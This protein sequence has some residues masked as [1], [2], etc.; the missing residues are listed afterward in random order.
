LPGS[1]PEPARAEIVGI[2]SDPEAP[3]P[4]GLVRIDAVNVLAAAGDGHDVDIEA[5]DGAIYLP[6]RVAL[7]LFGAPAERVK[8][9]T[10]SGTSM[11]PTL[12]PGQRIYVVL[13]RDGEEPADGAVYVLRGPQG[14]LVKRLRFESVVN[15]SADYFVTLVSDN[16]EFPPARYPMEV[17][18][19]D[20][21]VV[22]HVQRCETAL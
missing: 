7:D 20:F 10:V 12:Q 5:V 15:G 11:L 2:E 19:R 13:L 8:R 1:H 17:F 18:Y 4:P 21:T 6:E 3:P 16:P 14:V 9:I 22:A